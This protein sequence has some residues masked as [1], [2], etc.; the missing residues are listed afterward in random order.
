MSCKIT[1]QDEK[2]PALYNDRNQTADTDSIGSP[3]K[4][5]SFGTMWKKTVLVFD[6]LSYRTGSFSRCERNKVHFWHLL[7]L[8]L[9]RIVFFTDLRCVGCVS[10]CVLLQAVRCMDLRFPFLRFF[11]MIHHIFINL[12][13]FFPIS[14]FFYET[15][16]F[17]DERGEIFWNRFS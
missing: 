8:S 9:Q 3:G 13:I 6:K 12:S 4:I 17:C 14:S 10:G 16:F 11:A 7:V 15:A 1:C 2:V 5:R